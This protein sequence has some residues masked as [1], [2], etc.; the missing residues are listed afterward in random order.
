MTPV[1]KLLKIAR[2]EIGYLEKATNSNLDDKTANSG[3]NNWN[4]YARDLDKTNIYNGKKNGYSWCDIFCDWCFVT[5]FGF[6][7]ALEI[8]GQKTNGYGAGCTESVRYYKE[9]GWFFKSNPQP[10][11]QIFFSNDGGKS[12]YHTGLVE[13]VTPDRIYT[14][15]GNTGDPGLVRKRERVID[16]DEIIAYGSW[17]K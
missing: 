4:K 7:K 6:D 8:T 2:N 3:Y 11:D 16:S 13:K 14:I 5:A 1:E 15:E 17:Y 9:K 12:F 10:G